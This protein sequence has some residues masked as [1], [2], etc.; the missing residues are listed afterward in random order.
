MVGAANTVHSQCYKLKIIT[1]LPSG[2]SG[3]H[4]IKFQRLKTVD[5]FPVGNMI[6]D[7]EEVREG[8]KRCNSC[9]QGTRIVLIEICINHF[10]LSIC[11]LVRGCK[12]FCRQV[13]KYTEDEFF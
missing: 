6:F 2:G 11:I 5:D 8:L 1:K 7:L 3:R 9:N 4:F 13:S 12:H 10:P